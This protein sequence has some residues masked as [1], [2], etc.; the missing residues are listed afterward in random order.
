MRTDCHSSERR[1][2]DHADRRDPGPFPDTSSAAAAANNLAWICAGR[3]G[4]LGMALAL[5]Q[6]AGEGL[7]P[8]DADHR[9]GWVYLPDWLAVA[10]DR[11]LQ[12]QSREGPNES[13]VHPPPR[14]GLCGGRRLVQLEALFGGGSQRTQQRASAAKRATRTQRDLP[15]SVSFLSKVSRTSERVGNPGAKPRFSTPFEKSKANARRYQKPK[16]RWMGWL[17]ESGLVI[18][19]LRQSRKRQRKCWKLRASYRLSSLARSGAAELFQE[20]VISHAS[21]PDRRYE[22]GA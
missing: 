10:G 19:R 9:L 5:A 15:K 21:A 8:A 4:A 11:R 6:L 12:A 2:R 16:R 17:G 20:L 7:N 3:G 14:S 22:Q 13:P 18:S 1:A